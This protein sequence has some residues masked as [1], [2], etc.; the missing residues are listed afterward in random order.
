MLTP[1]QSTRRLRAWLLTCFCVGL[2]LFFAFNSNVESVLPLPLQRKQRHDTNH[3]ESVTASDLLQD[4][5]NATLG[6]SMRL[7]I[8]RP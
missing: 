4:V 7:T 1:T 3:N 2:L 6:V 5:S 8:Q